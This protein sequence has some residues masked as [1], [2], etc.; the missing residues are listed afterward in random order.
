M[1][2]LIIFKNRPLFIPKALKHMSIL[3]TLCSEYHVLESDFKNIYKYLYPSNFQFIRLATKCQILAKTPVVS[4]SQLVVQTSPLPL[5]LAGSCLNVHVYDH[6]CLFLFSLR[7][8]N[9]SLFSPEYSIYIQV[10]K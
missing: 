2:L 5:V 4:K 3:Y 6:M 7:R 10:Y 8:S 1:Y 9:I